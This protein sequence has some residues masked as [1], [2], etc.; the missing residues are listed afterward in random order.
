MKFSRIVRTSLWMILALLAARVHAEAIDLIM[1][2]KPAGGWRFNNG[3]EFPGA[4]GG[5]S[6][7]TDAAQPT[8]VLHGDFTKGGNY[9]DCSRNA[10][11][12]NFDRLTFRMK[13]PG[14]SHIT[15]RLVD[16][17]DQCHQIDVK[18]AGG[19]DWQNVDFPILDFFKNMGT[20]AS[21]PNIGRYEKW[22][23]ANDGRWHGPCKNIIFL[24]GKSDKS[25]TCDLSLTDIRIHPNEGVMYSEGFDAGSPLPKGWDGQ[26]DV[27]LDATA[28]N[29]GEKSLKLSRTVEKLQQET[30]ASGPAFG[31]A[32]GPWRIGGAVRADLNS[33]DNSY[34]GTV[35]IH[36][37][38]ASG[39][40]LET[41][42][43]AE[44]FKKTEW[45]R[46]DKRVEL[47]QGTAQAKIVAKMNKADGSFWVDDLS[48][49]R[50]EENVQKRVERIEISTDRIGN[51]L[52]PE[53]KTIAHVRVQALRA[54]KD[55]ELTLN[56]TVRD[57][58]G[59][60]QAAPAK[61]TLAA[62]GKKFSYKADLDLSA[63]NME[64]GRYYEL[65]VE[66]P[67]ASSPET[68]FTGIARLP[69]AAAKKCA[70]DDIPFSIRNWDNRIPDYMKLSDRIGHRS[71]GL[72]GGFEAKAPYK[73]QLPG[74]ELI[75]ELGA[76]WVTSTP[77]AQVEAHGFKDY[78]EEGLREGMTN[79][80]K[81]YADKDL[82]FICMGNEPHGKLPKVKENV[83]AYKAIYEAVKAFDPKIVVVSTSVEPN[84]DYFNEG[85]YK[86]HDIYD[87]HEY[88][89]Y[90]GVRK[91]LQ[92]Y[93]KLMQKYNAVK[94]II[95]TEVGLN[96]QGMT[97]YAVA[98]EMVK[99]FSV[100]FAEGGSNVSWFTIQYPDPKGQAR[101]TSG[102]A[103]CVFDCKYSL[104]N[105]RLDAIS[106]Y[107]MLNGILVKKFAA[108]K[109]YP[110]GT[111]A[112]LFK[113]KDRNCLVSIW[114]DTGRKDVSLPLAGVESA[115]LIRIDGSRVKLTP[116]AG[117]VTLGVSIEPLVLV[118]SQKD[119]KLPEALG[120][121][122][123]ALA[124]EL[125]AAAKGQETVLKISGAGLTPQALKVSA[126][127]LWT[128]ST[129]AAGADVECVLKS[130]DVSAV[131]EGRVS[132]QRIAGDKI[133]G[134]LMI[135]LP[136]K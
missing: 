101:G 32:P 112:Y 84:E 107:F 36:A 74:I 4:T 28:P 67:R 55:N 104:Y 90:T 87:Y 47:P 123:M 33:P 30:G 92:E 35:S 132:V 117:N 78:T 120:A 39:A 88:G 7:A 22:G 111:Q 10:P 44:I 95:S 128:V 25:P 52:L 12:V 102:D 93:K 43:V 89:T 31:A 53:D 70:A 136:V 126:P 60:E 8:L 50:L 94:P 134:E 124:S 63:A 72:W 59:A 19:D 34:N 81:Q 15:M 77:A 82:A 66:L 75:K 61:V 108:E 97:R 41:H 62:D 130:P 119:A 113:D 133:S 115:E 58:W 121:P 135:T 76:K 38:A 106:Y 9:V 83:R 131:R 110:D 49:T 54:L 71:I 23:G 14:K 48:A 46:F 40:V 27:S 125:K 80:L 114:N 105:P 11:K 68:E 3:A 24:L 96:S 98:T 122:A 1:T 20:A 16:M 109:V 45:L 127:P 99:T 65:H 91:T 37:L 51:L 18:V 6:L 21:I 26:G 118:Y 86:Y 73:P 103:H 79:F 42:V 29:K 13:A 17:S 69:E 116:D 5:V 129:R 2:D 100:F 85:Y 64:I 56:W 57:Y